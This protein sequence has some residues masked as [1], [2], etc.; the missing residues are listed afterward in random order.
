MAP[1]R[2]LLVLLA[3]V[4]DA[5]G[6]PG[7]SREW[8]Q[9]RGGPEGTNAVDVAAILGPPKEAWRA[10][11][12]RLDS[13]PVVSAGNIYV[14]GL[15]KSQEG[16]RHRL[17]VMDVD[18][19]KKV[20]D[21]NLDPGGKSWVAVW[22]GHVAILGSEG[23]QILRQWGTE[24]PPTKIT[25]I[26]GSFPNPPCVA[27]GLLF[28]SDAGGALHVI[29]LRTGEDTVARKQV[30]CGR[31]AA[32][33]GEAKGTFLVATAGVVQDAWTP[34][35]QVDGSCLAMLVTGVPGNSELES[36]YAELAGKSEPSEVAG[37]AYTAHV[38]AM[39]KG[40][41]GTW[42]V[43]SPAQVRAADG[44][45]F[46]SVMLPNAISPL[47]TEAAVVGP[48]AIGFTS[49]GELAAFRSDGLTASILAKDAPFPEGARRHGVTAARGTLYLENWA[50]RIED[51]KVLWSAPWIDST[52]PLIPAANGRAIYTTEKNEIVC[53]VD[54]TLSE[55]VE[56]THKPVLPGTGD[57]VVTSDG[58]WLAGTITEQE[59]GRILLT[60]N[61]G[62]P[63]ILEPADVALLVSGQRVERRG[64][65]EMV[66]R[67]SFAALRE[68]CLKVFA[69]LVDRRQEAGLVEEAGRLL[70]E[71]R[72][73]DR[74]HAR[75]DDLERDLARRTPVNAANSS[76]VATRMRKEEA[77]AKGN[78]TASFRKAAG[79]CN[80]NGMPISA[81]ALLLQ[82]LRMVEESVE[83]QGDAK[84]LIPRGFPD[85]DGKGAAQRW[86]QLALELL[87]SDAKVVSRDDPCWE[88]VQSMPWSQKAIALRTENVL[89]MSTATEPELLG[90]CL[91]NGENTVRVLQA[92][93]PWVPPEGSN[94]EPL[95]VRVH[96][97]QAEYL[98]QFSERGR[99]AMKWTGGF[100]W[101]EDNVSRFFVPRD[102]EKDPLERPL[103]RLLV[104]EMTHQYIAARWS[105]TV[106]GRM[107]GYET[108]PGFWIVEG[109]ARFLEDQVVEMNK[110][111]DKLDAETAWSIDAA[112][113]LCEQGRLI[114]MNVFLDM[115]QRDYARLKT[116]TTTTI[117]LRH[118]IGPVEVSPMATF[119]EQAGS[120]TFFLWHQGGDAG[121]QRLLDY[122]RSWYTWQ[123]RRKSWE[124]LGYPS[125][126]A[127]EKDYQD[128]LKRH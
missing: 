55:R 18:T 5:A 78:L 120:L 1:T 24:F 102:E 2:C 67:A 121:R 68:E 40:R 12:K 28:A 103:E 107:S 87:P 43:F 64:R 27:S 93:L 72:T 41:K 56:A 29:D 23:I 112:A 51:G 89:L 82:A 65:E 32:I 79:W 76:G 60:P 99:K 58:R 113:R 30:G 21:T 109:I 83:V 33:P 108:G 4:L 17:F 62:E 13:E 128:F 126:E 47:A 119:Y 8:S 59:A 61:K 84:A 39:E 74:D 70:D 45:A 101:V 98:A 124:M 125:A 110:H 44:E 105:R 26:A 50:V 91:T 11:F 7:Q 46:H 54:S 73:W 42:F 117:L 31:P 96:T 48:A 9:P 86:T 3:L 104:H 88:K 15:A 111:G 94:A 75:W 116:K 69:T 115:D 66:Y 14:V 20:A 118:T 95:N 97:D 127:L 90:H 80:Q 16:T 35:G 25:R 123:T 38:P 100:Y 122:L 71:A 53:I 34:S 19:G 106:H 36:V 37:H 114:P 10:P 49:D 81:S 6:A 22:A 52:S 77:Q 63:R 57:G 92:V 85:P